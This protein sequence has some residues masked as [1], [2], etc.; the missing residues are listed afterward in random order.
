MSYK[1]LTKFLARQHTSK[2]SIEEK[3]FSKT[4][5]KQNHII[6]M[7]RNAKSH[8]VFSFRLSNPTSKTLFHQ[9]KKPLKDKENVYRL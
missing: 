2:H 1:I 5:G 9:L 7:D 3:V 6:P 8:N 4:L